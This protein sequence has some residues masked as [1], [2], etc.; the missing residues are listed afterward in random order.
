MDLLCQSFPPLFK[1]GFLSHCLA[2][3]NLKE[4]SKRRLA[5]LPCLV[6]SCPVNH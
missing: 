3:F 5:S 2:F 6:L 4:M 1:E